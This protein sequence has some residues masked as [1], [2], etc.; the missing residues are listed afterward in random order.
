MRLVHTPTLPRPQPLAA[1]VLFAALCAAY[2]PDLGHGFIKDDFRWIRASRVASIDDAADLLTQNVGF[3]RPV[4]SASFALNYAAAGLEPFA[5]GLTNFALL[6]AAAALLFLL[7]RRLDLPNES[8]LLAA[9]LWVFNFHGINM[10]LLWISGRTALLLC[11]CA[12]AA[13]LC[14]LSG[15]AVAGGV[16]C[17][18]ALLSK[19]EAVALPFMLALELV[20]DR[21]MSP[22]QIA[23]ATWP[24]FAALLI[25][26]ALRTQS[27]AFG[28]ADAPP[29]YRFTSDPGV[30][31]RN[32]LEYIDR[33]ATWPAILVAI[34][35]IA[36][37][38]IPRFT[39]GDRRVLVF[40]ALWFGF[41]YALTIFVPV[42][43]SLYA[44]F[45][46]IG[47]CLAAAAAAAALLRDRPARV[48]RALA[49]LVFLPLLLVPVYRA[50][51]VRWVSLADLSS[52]VLADLRQ[53]A[54]AAPDTQRIVL[55]DDPGARFNLDAAFGTLL[56]DALVLFVGPYMDG[57]IVD[58]AQFPRVSAPEGTLAFRLRAGALELEPDPAGPTGPEPEAQSPESKAQSL[59]NLE[60]REH[61][62]L[63]HTQTNRPRRTGGRHGDLDPQ[64]LPHRPP[65]GIGHVLGDEI[66]DR[67][68]EGE[69]RALRAGHLNRQERRILGRRCHQTIAFNAQRDV[70]QVVRRRPRERGARLHLDLQPHVA[71]ADRQVGIDRRRA[72]PHAREPGA[73]DE[74]LG[75]HGRHDEHV[76]QRDDEAVAKAAAHACPRAWIRS[77]RLT[78]SSAHPPAR[79]STPRPTRLIDRSSLSI[80]AEK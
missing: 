47:A 38:A 45:P 33:A 67:P 77:F 13:A 3:Y 76:Q 44:V 63:P 54:S 43:S 4:V 52:I 79:N 53:A 2:L 27:G 20:L 26:A 39:V 58:A 19:E 29:Y 68:V 55:I 71:A 49:V 41:G 60:R 5:Y 6:L 80:T 46:S 35:M 28:P 57:A 30:L 24:L 40:G 75:A 36:A 10:A 17:L 11:L 66:G 65:R 78:R 18:A 31:V 56:P 72:R 69:E 23:R 25:Y 14:T 51:N 37:R 15:R 8:A 50:R 7:A 32:V 70:W 59:T 73:I 62:V 22:A 9:A 48:H 34:M 42:R 61:A 64:F 21:R 12:M 16:L 74:Q 1:G